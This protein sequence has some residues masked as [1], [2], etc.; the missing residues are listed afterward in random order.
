LTDVDAARFVRVA[1]PALV[2]VA[3]IVLWYALVKA[4]DVPKYLV[5]SPVDV[6]QTLVADWGLLSRALLVTLRITFLAFL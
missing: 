5:P 3:V 6:A 2:G 1:A 4:F